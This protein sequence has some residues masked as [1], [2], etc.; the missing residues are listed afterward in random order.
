MNSGQLTKQKAL[1]EKLSWQDQIENLPD[2]TRLNIGSTNPILAA[3]LNHKRQLGGHYQEALYWPPASKTGYRVNL[4]R[5]EVD[6]LQAL[7]S[8]QWVPI[9]SLKGVEDTRKPVSNLRAF[10]LIIATAYR[11]GNGDCYRLIG[12]IDLSPP[13]WESSH[14]LQVA[15]LLPDRETALA[16]EVERARSAFIKRVALARKRAAHLPPQQLQLP[17]TSS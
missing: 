17:K 1:Q 7:A 12:R 3:E 9:Q 16:A 5:R 11:P 6:I 15:D 2:N 13:L 4:N 8:F 14:S 10:G